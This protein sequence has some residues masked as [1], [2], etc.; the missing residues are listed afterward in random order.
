M[1]PITISSALRSPL[2]LIGVMALGLASLGFA[3]PAQASFTCVQNE[4]YSNEFGFVFKF[5]RASDC[6]FAVTHS[7]NGFACAYKTL[8]SDKKGLL[9]KETSSAAACED[10]VKNAK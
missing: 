2:T 9:I 3:N 6:E 8:F 4:L 5:D 10:A 1:N 7:N